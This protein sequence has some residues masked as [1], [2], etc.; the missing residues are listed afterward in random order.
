M[1]TD[2]TERWHH[3]LL[4]VK[5]VWEHWRMKAQRLM[6]ILVFTSL[7]LSSA[8]TLASCYILSPLKSKNSWSSAGVQSRPLHWFFESWSYWSQPPNYS[9]FFQPP[10][11]IEF[12]FHV[13]VFQIPTLLYFIFKE[14]VEHKTQITKRNKAW[15]PV[16]LRQSG[17]PFSSDLLSS[18]PNLRRTAK[19]LRAALKA[20]TSQEVKKCLKAGKRRLQ[21]WNST[22]NCRELR[23]W[24]GKRKDRLR[25]L[26]SIVRGKNSQRAR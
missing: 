5:C 24:K 2:C 9:C 22:S 21:V 14:T 12:V 17:R 7:A 13:A 1:C 10:N 16:L 20:N 11:L 26:Q 23:K 4:N 25:S 3:K 15:T 8:A 18:F 19:S 6:L